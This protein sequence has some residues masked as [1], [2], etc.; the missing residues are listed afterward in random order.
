V[1][2]TVSGSQHSL[3][4]QHDSDC[5]SLDRL[6]HPTGKDPVRLLSSSGHEIVQQRQTYGR[7]LQGSGI[8]SR[9]FHT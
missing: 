1:V 3:I 8:V 7:V 2:T 6:Q 5:I 9:F 4:S